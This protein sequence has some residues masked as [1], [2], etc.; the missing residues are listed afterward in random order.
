MRRGGDSYYVLVNKD[1]NVYE[2]SNFTGDT[3]TVEFDSWE[4]AEEELNYLVDVN[5]LNKEDGWHVERHR[6]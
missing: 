5:G 4:E 1:G 2:D 6:W 3:W